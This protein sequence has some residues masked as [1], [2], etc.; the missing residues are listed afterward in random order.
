MLSLISGKLEPLKGIIVRPRPFRKFTALGD[1]KL[2][3]LE[4]LPGFIPLSFILTEDERFFRHKGVNFRAF[5][6][7]QYLI[8]TG[9]SYIGSGSSITEQTMR[10]FFLGNSNR[11]SMKLKKVIFAFHAER[12][13]TKEQILALYLSN[14]RMGHL[15]NGLENASRYYFDKPPA[16]LKVFEAI[17]LAYAIR[18]PLVIQGNVLHK[19][20]YEQFHAFIRI[21]SFE[22]YFFFVSTFGQESLSRIAEFSFA[23]IKNGLSDYAGRKTYKR[24]SSQIYEEVEWLVLDN[25]QEFRSWFLNPAQINFVKN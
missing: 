14:I 13:F 20:D 25:L 3:N 23:Q 21:K 15:A 2:I 8:L 16:K 10:R 6:H 5:L 7:R 22:L 4:S 18:N 9:N 12:L 1:P 17:F 11:V 19:L 24:Y